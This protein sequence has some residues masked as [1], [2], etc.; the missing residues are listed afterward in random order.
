MKL[1]VAGCSHT[2]GA[3]VLEKWHPGDPSMCYGKVLA[4]YYK[5]DEYVNI[6]G[7]GFSNQWIYHKTIEFLEQQDNPSEWFV[8]IGWTNASRLAVYDHERNEMVHLCPSHR[9]LEHFSHTIRKAYDHLYK[10]M[11]P[12]MDSIHI[13]HNRIIGMQSFLKQQSIKYLFFDA[14]WTNHDQCSPKFI[15]TNRYF[16]YNDKQNTYWE[17]YYNNVWDKSE[18]WANHAPYEYHR[19]WA[20]ELIVYINQNKLVG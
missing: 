12:I 19:F 6:A 17:Y 15:D 13:E 7:P 11:L 18:R 8:V 1:L 20:N 2:S 16:R 14:V 5:A 9:N 10:T 3:E 4:D